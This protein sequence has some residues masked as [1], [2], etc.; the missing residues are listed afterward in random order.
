MKLTDIPTEMIE[1][2]TFLED[3]LQ[4]KVTTDMVETL[5]LHLGRVIRGK[6]TSSFGR[7]AAEKIQSL[8]REQFSAWIVERG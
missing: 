2:E 3:Y 8:S 7:E 5:S 1:R 6:R 4:G